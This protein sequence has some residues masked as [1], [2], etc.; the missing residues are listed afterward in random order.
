MLIVT[1]S[2]SK[3]NIVRLSKALF[4]IDIIVEVWIGVMTGL[5]ARILVLQCGQPGRLSCLFD[6]LLK[7]RLCYCLRIAY[8]LF[9]TAKSKKSL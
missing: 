7:A 4:N 9:M 5:F 3:V 8:F 1:I 2:I 6:V